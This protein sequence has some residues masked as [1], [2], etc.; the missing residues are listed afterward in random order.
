[1]R[2]VEIISSKLLNSS[3]KNIDDADARLSVSVYDYKLADNGT[4]VADQ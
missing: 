4:E 3:K 2:Y 1:M